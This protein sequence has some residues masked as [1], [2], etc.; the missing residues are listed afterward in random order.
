MTGIS[1]LSLLFRINLIFATLL[2]NFLCYGMCYNSQLNLLLLLSDT[3]TLS[4]LSVF[5]WRLPTCFRQVLCFHRQLQC[6]GLRHF[7]CIA[8]YILQSASKCNSI[9]RC[10]CGPAVKLGFDVVLYQLI[11]VDTIIILSAPSQQ[12]H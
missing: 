1:P 4:I 12:S 9:L 2:K 8:L 5:P 11:P 6:E 10:S 3:A 7:L